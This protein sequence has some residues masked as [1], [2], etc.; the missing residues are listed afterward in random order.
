MTTPLTPADE[1]RS[2]ARLLR[3]RAAAATAGPWTYDPTKAWHLPGLH[4]DEEFI[5]SRS[6]GQRTVCVAATGPASDPQSMADAAWIATMHPLV[7][8][9]LATWLEREA[10]IWDALETAKV[11]LAPTGF[12]LSWGISTHTE[13][14]AVARTLL[15]VR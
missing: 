15:A 10:E 6:S 7:G 11:E 3:E 14:L 13:A 12:K 2:A 1:L 4:F 8:E 9:V 5:G